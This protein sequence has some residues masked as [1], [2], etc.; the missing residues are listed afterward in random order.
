MKKWIDF[1]KKHIHKVNKYQITI[2]IFLVVTF[3]VGDN[4]FLDGIRYESKIK[5]LRKEVE[6]LK[7]ENDKKLR[8][9]N[10]LQG[11][12]ED[13]EKF[14]REQFLMT[15]ADEELFLIVE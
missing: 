14:A 4:T 6:S 3:F 5:S 9:L 2:V 13:L 1:F 10:A 15:K 7:I 8:Q 12:K 11:D